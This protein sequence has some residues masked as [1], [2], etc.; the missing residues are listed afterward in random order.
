[1]K[2]GRIVP[3]Y[4]LYNPAKGHKKIRSRTPKK[5]LMSPEKKCQRWGRSGFGP[6]CYYRGEHPACPCP[7]RMAGRHGLLPR[8]TPKPF[9]ACVACFSWQMWEF[10]GVMFLKKNRNSLGTSCLA[11]SSTGATWATSSGLSLGNSCPFLAQERWLCD[12]F[13]GDGETWCGCVGTL[14]WI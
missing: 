11:L 3:L 2:I 12:K 4:S 14:V 1:M 6:L 9:L 13:V 7:R 10:R 8:A 5:G